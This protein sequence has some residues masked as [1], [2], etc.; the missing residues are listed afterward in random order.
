M[1]ANFL[2][3]SVPVG[4]WTALGALAL[5]HSGVCMDIDHKGYAR[6]GQRIVLPFACKGVCMCTNHKG[7]SGYRVADVYIFYI[8]RACASVINVGHKYKAASVGHGVNK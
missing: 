8:K 3:A 6:L 7:N 5:P 2:C 1:A 4:L